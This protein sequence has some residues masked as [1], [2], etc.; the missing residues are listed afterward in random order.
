MKKRV[1]LTSLLLP[2]IFISGCSAS[3]NDDK[4]EPKEITV[5]KQPN[6]ITKNKSLIDSTK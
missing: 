6:K 4:T 2:I 1:I 3:G 5:K